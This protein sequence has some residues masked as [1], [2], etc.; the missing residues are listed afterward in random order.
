MRLDHD[1]RINTVLHEEFLLFV[2]AAGVCNTGDIFCVTRGCMIV[3][4][5]GQT[6]GISEGHL[7]V[8]YGWS[9]KVV[10]LDNIAIS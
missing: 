4:E 9:V 10:I 8:I 2:S 3:S 6:V 5:T 1:Y 7:L